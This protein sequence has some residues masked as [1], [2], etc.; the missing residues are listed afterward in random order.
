MPQ[1]HRDRIDRAIKAW[2][3]DAHYHTTGQRAQHSEVSIKEKTIKGKII[4]LVKGQTKEGT[5]E[6]ILKYYK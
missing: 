3:C 1:F 2:A 4:V 5:P 6:E